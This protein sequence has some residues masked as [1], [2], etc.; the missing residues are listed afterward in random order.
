MYSKWTVVI[1]SEVGEKNKY[2]RRL[3]GLVYLL[4]D[5][6]HDSEKERQEKRKK[7]KE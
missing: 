1:R 7:E 2:A 3:S 6:A 5:C 4:A